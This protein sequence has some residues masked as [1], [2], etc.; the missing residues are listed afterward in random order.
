MVHGLVA[1]KELR[2]EEVRVTLHELAVN[3]TVFRPMAKAPTSG[4]LGILSVAAQFGRSKSGLDGFSHTTLKVSATAC[5]HTR[6][7]GGAG[8]A[9]I[10]ALGDDV[11]DGGV[12]GASVDVTLHIFAV[13]IVEVRNV[14]V[15]SCGRLKVVQL[16]ILATRLTQLNQSREVSFQEGT[17]RLK[18]ILRT[19]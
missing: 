19:K 14:A 12:H 17:E 18:V 5:H 7:A 4:G 6:P 16:V 13:L 9:K 8:S 15:V 2:S 10:C 3:T 1:A 11:V